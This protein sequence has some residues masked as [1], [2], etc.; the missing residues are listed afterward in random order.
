MV[1][2]ANHRAAGVAARWAR[3]SRPAAAQRGADAFDRWLAIHRLR[4]ERSLPR[5]VF[6]DHPAGPRPCYVDFCDPFA[7]EE[8]ARQEP[9]E[10][11]IT[12]MLPAPGQ[13]WWRVDGREQCAE[14]RLG[15]VVRSA[16]R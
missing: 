12:E 5:H 14:L 2:A 8:L 4:R 13:L 9:A 6:V 7:V 1:S 15:C 11:L 3:P 16:A 10:V